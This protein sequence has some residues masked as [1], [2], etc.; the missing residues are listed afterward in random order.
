MAFKGLL[1]DVIDHEPRMWRDEID[2]VRALMRPGKGH[3]EMASFLG[4]TR[5]G[6][7]Q[8]KKIGAAFRG[9]KNR[10]DMDSG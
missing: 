4:V 8:I 2:D 10:L 9:M 3:D 1:V 7:T 5:D 6:S